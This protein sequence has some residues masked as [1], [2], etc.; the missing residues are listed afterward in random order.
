LLKTRISKLQFSILARST[1]YACPRI[2]VPQD[3]MCIFQR[4]IGEDQGEPKVACPL[5]KNP[6]PFKKREKHKC[7]LDHIATYCR[8]KIEEALY[9]LVF[10][11]SFGKKTRL[12]IWPRKKL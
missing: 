1:W 6:F 11:N 8:V 10:L 9:I 12:K 7:D 2:Y 5:H 3:G 4:M